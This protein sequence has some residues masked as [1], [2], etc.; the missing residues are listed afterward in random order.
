MRVRF[1]CL[2]K[3]LNWSSLDGQ[4]PMSWSPGAQVG[5]SLAE[6]SARQAFG[7]RLHSKYHGSV[8]IQRSAVISGPNR[9]SPCTGKPLPTM[10]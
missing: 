9:D 6:H 1:C 8:D 10:E 2:P 4:Q 7:P 5:K 3:A